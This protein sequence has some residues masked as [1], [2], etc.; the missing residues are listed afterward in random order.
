ME[1]PMPWTEWGAEDVW[2]PNAADGVW[3]VLVIWALMVLGV[4]LLM[5]LVVDPTLKRPPWSA[6]G[7]ASVAT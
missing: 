3:W 4:L 7:P 5:L 1:W 2:V 6:A